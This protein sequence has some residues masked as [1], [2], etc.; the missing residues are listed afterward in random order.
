MNI[1]EKFEVLF[2][3]IS[4][5]VYFIVV[6]MISV[7]PL[8]MINASFFIDILFFFLMELFPLSTIIFWIWGLIKAIQGPQDWLAVV[9]YIGFAVLFLP[10][11]ISTIIKL[12]SRK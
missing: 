6:L 4:G 5:I 8:I 11:I 2:G 12:F 1:K 7:L 9:Y 10:F 3:A